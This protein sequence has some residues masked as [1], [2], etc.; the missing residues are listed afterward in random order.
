[1]LIS[2]INQST[3]V[4]NADAEIMTM[5]CNEQLQRDVLPALNIREGTIQFFA[6]KTKV[7]S[8]AWVF[9]ILDSPAQAGELGF[10]TIEASGLIDAFI[11]A[12]PVLSNGGVVLYDMTNPQNV[13]VASV[14]AHEAIE[15]IGDPFANSYCDFNGK[16][17]AYEFCDAVQS[18]SYTINVNGHN[19]SVSNFVY[20]SYFDPEGTAPFDHLNT[21]TAPFTI[22]PGGYMIVRSGGPSTET[23]VFGDKMPCWQREQKK[24][25]FSRFAYRQ[26]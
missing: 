11:F 13:S 4:S 16:S 18:Q 23:E 24:G 6:D 2:V 20:A 5:A 21:L 25:E 14:L 7:P 9:N 3:L 12:Q 8:N 17:F 22:E 19:V 1:M 15:A 10:H 26:K